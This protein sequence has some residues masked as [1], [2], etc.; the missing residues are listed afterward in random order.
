M[1]VAD[2]YNWFASV[3]ESKHRKGIIKTEFDLA[4]VLD[5]LGGKGL[6]QNVGDK[7]Y[8]KYKKKWT[9]R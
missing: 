6:S 5:D 2:E 8:Y 9:L 3:L 7:L 1:K 4:A